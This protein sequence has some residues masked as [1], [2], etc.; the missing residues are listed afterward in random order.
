[1][2]FEKNLG[3]FIK[4]RRE[5]QGLSQQEL[6]DEICSLS[7]AQ[8]IEQNEQ[9]PTLEKLNLI[10]NRLDMSITEFDYIFRDDENNKTLAFIQKFIKLGNSSNIDDLLNLQSEIIAANKSIKSNFL[11]HL[12]LLIEAFHTYQTTQSFKKAARIAAPIWKE[13]S[14][15]NK[16]Y[17]SDVF[18]MANVFY[19]FNDRTVQT[20]ITRLTQELEKYKSFAWTDNYKITIPLN[21]A[22]YLKSK[23]KLSA[24][25]SYLEAAELAFSNSPHKDIRYLADIL[26]KFA[27]LAYFNGEVEEAQNKVQDILQG[28]ETFKHFSLQKDLQNDWAEFITECHDKYE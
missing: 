3:T 10:I 28:L 4:E 2:K 1:M 21:Y 17:Y 23:G 24:T 12:T 7:S 5:D 6:Y 8:R 19:I 20:I 15:K 9:I 22:S 16:W 11:R 18:L 27:E 25:K 13:L 14:Q 26:Y